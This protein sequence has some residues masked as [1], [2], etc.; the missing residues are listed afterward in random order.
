ML[1]NNVRDGE[2]VVPTGRYFVLGDNRD[3]SLD[4]RYWGFVSGQ[5]MIGRPIL[6]YGSFDKQPA[7]IF[8]TR[9]SRLFKRP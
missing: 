5:E 4:S 9:W 8:N 2:L 7:S 1:K 6:I 3:S